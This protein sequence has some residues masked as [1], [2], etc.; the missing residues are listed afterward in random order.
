MP[1][2]TGS[3]AQDEV[4]REKGRGKEGIL[5]RNFGCSS[6]EKKKPPQGVLV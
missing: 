1:V 4:A 3:S 5:P 6:P 2:E